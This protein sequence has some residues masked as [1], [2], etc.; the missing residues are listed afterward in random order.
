VIVRVVGTEQGH[1]CGSKE[2][3][4]RVRS[5]WVTAGYYIIPVD[6]WQRRQ[7]T[8]FL[9]LMKIYGGIVRTLRT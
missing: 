6:L 4:W 3:W 5:G 7:N 9:F 2:H 1:R 8:K